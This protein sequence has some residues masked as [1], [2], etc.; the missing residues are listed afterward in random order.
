M[1]RPVQTGILGSDS[2]RRRHEGEQKREGI[3]AMTHTHEL[4]LRGCSPDPL[5]SYLK[6]LGIFRLVS[7]QA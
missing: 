1:A 4:K 3:R 2:S 6:A 5:M 7:E